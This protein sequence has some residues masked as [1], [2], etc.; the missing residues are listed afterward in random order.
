MKQSKTELELKITQQGNFAKL[1]QQ[2]RVLLVDYIE[3]WYG[4]Q[5]GAKT[6]FARDQG[7]SSQQVNRWLKLGVYIE[8][9]KLNRPDPKPI[10]LHVPDW[11]QSFCK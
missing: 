1:M 4:T 10:E 7:V 9:G 6:K 11:I 5:H 2:G 3:F 8:K